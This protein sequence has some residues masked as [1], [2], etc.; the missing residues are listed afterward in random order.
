MANHH[1][2]SLTRK[3]R[4]QYK[5]QMEH[6]LFVLLIFFTSFHALAQVKQ[7]KKKKK[8]KQRMLYFVFVVEMSPNNNIITNPNHKIGGG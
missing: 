8:M 5:C 4:F 2:L 1:Q 3:A 7:K 6:S